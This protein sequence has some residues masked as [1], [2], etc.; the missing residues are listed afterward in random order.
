MQNAFRALEKG[1][2]AEAVEYI[3]L[4][5]T[6]SKT[7]NDV[8]MHDYRGE[9]YFEVHTNVDYSHLDA[10]AAFKCAESW[11]AV[12]KHPKAKKWFDKDEI[13]TKI[14]NA[15]V[16]LFNKAA[17]L[18]YAGN[19]QSALDPSTRF[20]IFSLDE[21][22]IFQEVMLLRKYMVYFFSYCN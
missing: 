16:A 20:L 13:N 18:Y 17:E 6:N 15:G 3:E 4:A 22:E 5:A 1:N 7:A 19:H 21:K 8:K 9:I 14:T 12:A 10:M 11:E 2:I